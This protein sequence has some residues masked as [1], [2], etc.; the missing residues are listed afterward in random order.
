[1]QLDTKG[2]KKTEKSKLEFYLSRATYKTSARQRKT[3]EKCS[4]QT[5]RFRASPSSSFLIKKSLERVAISFCDTKEVTTVFK[6]NSI[7][8]H[9]VAVSDHTQHKR[10]PS[11]R[12]GSRERERIPLA[13]V[14]DYG[15]G[16]ERRFVNNAR[17]SKL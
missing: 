17:N 5:I 15:V 7:K 8:R 3:S 14:F 10:P 1:M 16:G 13:P 12:R 11:S 2:Q 6:T 4:K 9:R